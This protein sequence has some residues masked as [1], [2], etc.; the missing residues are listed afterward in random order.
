MLKPHRMA[1]TPIASP[2]SE[3]TPT[4]VPTTALTATPT[5]TPLPPS[6][7]T[8]PSTPSPAATA[9][10]TQTGWSQNLYR[11]SMVAS[12]G[13]LMAAGFIILAMRKLDK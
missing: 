13:L 1:F 10:P 2:T 4:A 3:A 5:V 12:V 6:P 11:G 8:S 9:V 7:T